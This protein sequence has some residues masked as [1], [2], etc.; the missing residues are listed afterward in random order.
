MSWFDKIKRY[1]VAGFWTVAM[2]RNAV[3]KGKITE[4][5]YKKI[6]GEAYD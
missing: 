4:D 2:V 5:E 3:I 6:T 1:Y